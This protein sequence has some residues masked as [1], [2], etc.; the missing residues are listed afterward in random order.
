MT[1]E[2]DCVRDVMLAVEELQ[3][4]DENG[5]FVRLG[6]RSIIKSY[7]CEGYSE[8]QMRHTLFQI[9]QSGLVIA[10]IRPRRSPDFDFYWVEYITPKGH[11]FLNNLRDNDVFAKIKGVLNGTTN[12]SLDIVSDIAKEL[13]KNILKQKLGLN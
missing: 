2:L 6:Y 3:Q 1:L 8:E 4:F 11:E 7:R 12:F 10:D 9:A 13:G 5:S